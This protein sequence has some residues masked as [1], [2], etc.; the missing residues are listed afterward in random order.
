[1][2]KIKKTSYLLLILYCWSSHG[3]VHL[4]TN[5]ADSGPGS[6]RQAII[7]ANADGSTPRTINFAIGAGV[8][9]ISPVTALPALVVP[10][11]IIDG[12]TQ[13]GW[14]A[15]NP[16]IVIDGTNAAFGF[17]G[18]TI[19]ATDACTI[20]DL[21]INNGFNS[22]ITI[23]GN[24]AD[25][26][27]Y[28]CFIGV[29]QTGT[30]AAPNSL[31]IT[32]SAT[33][34]EQNNNTIIGAPTRGN[35]VSGNAGFFGAGLFL[36]GNL[37]DMVVQG[38]FIGTDITGTV[39][40]ANAQV[41][42]AIISQP[43]S[44]AVVCNGALIGGSGAGE[45]NVMSGNST[46]PGLFM[47]FQNV[48]DTIIQ[49]NK[50][51]VDVT[52]TVAVP[53]GVGI[54][55]FT[56]EPANFLNGTILGGANAGEGNVI[57]ANP[58]GGVGLQV[59]CNNSIIK[60]NFIG[61]DI[62]GTVA[63]G[64]GNGINIQGNNNIIGGSTAAERNIIS[65]NTGSGVFIG[66]GSSSNVVTGNYIG[67]D[68]T[69]TVAMG[70]NNIGVEITGYDFGTLT[71]IPSNSNIVGGA[72]AGERNII[73]NSGSSGILLNMG[74]NDTVIKG[75]Y[76]GVDVTGAVD[77]GNSNVG[78][79]IQGYDFTNQITVPC[80]RTIIGGAV[81]GEGNVIAGSTNQ[82]IQ[83]NLGINDS[84]IKGNKIGVDV[85]GLV[86][87][88]NG[89]QGIQM[90]GYD[91]TNKTIVA[92]DNTVI[93]GATTNE[94]N[95]ISG[96][97]NTGIQLNLGCNNTVIKGNYIGVDA[98]GI[99]A[100]SNTNQGI[101]I[102][103]FDFNPP[104][105]SAPCND[106][107][108][109]G[110]LAGERN[111]ISAN[112]NEG[113]QLNVDANDTII[114]GNYIGVGS[115]GTTALGNANQG[116]HVIGNTLAATNGTI[117]GGSATG[118]SNIISSN[119][120]DGIF[121]NRN[122]NNSVI[123]GNFIGTD[124]TG[125]LNRANG[126]NGINITGDTGQ[127]SDNTI[128]GGAAS[129]AGNL[130]VANV[131][132]GILL[133]NNVNNTVIK[134]NYVGTNSASSTILGNGSMGIQVNGNAAQPCVG[135]IIGGPLA[136]EGNVI[137]NN[138]VDGIWLNTSVN[139]SIIQGNFIG[140]NKTATIDLGNGDDGIQISGAGGAPC[141]NNLIGGTATAQKNII[142][143][144]TN[145]GVTIGGDAGSPDILNSVL[146]NPIY[147]NGNNGIELH[148]GGNNE[149]E[150]PTVDSV[151]TCT[152]NNTVQVT[153]TAPANPPASSF[154]LEYFLNTVDR[155]PITEGETFIGFTTPVPSGATVTNVF[156]APSASIGQWFSATAT[157]L[158]NTGGTPGDTSEFS[159]NRQIEAAIPP[160]VSLVATPTIICAGGSSTLTVTI[161]GTSPY[162][163]VW[164]DGLV[165]TDVTSPVQRVVTPSTTTVY[166]VTATDDVSCGSTS[167]NATVVVNPL[168]TVTLTADPIST[169][170]GGTVT[171]TATPSG[172]GP[173]TLEWS[174]G[175]VQNNVAGA[176][177][178]EVIINAPTTYSVVATDSNGCVSAPAQVQ[179]L[180]GK[181]S[182]IV[183]A[184]INKYCPNL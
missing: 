91:F 10:E 170:P 65:N 55:T 131:S 13:P 51:G 134:G 135:T 159:L 57:S 26:A 48:Q 67:V 86:A 127:L 60:G 138:T 66:Q 128:I 21:V 43:S 6:L 154:R 59:N 121:L 63:L 44:T 115:D 54:I 108:I 155:N 1:M 90:Y 52:G 157:N 78:I 24:A 163:L 139:D 64:N 137:G 45:G 8:Q 82:G 112:L 184:I 69:G 169:L 142:T 9:T 39:G 89:Q 102:S 148:D 126:Q 96:N 177:M 40:I 118:E 18:L 70:N 171:L 84:V 17:D 50:I 123:Q 124:I 93:G 180:I 76:I 36:S 153:V 174:D 183:I 83:L 72:S 150:A 25:N 22:G 37:N 29:D 53:N 38:N 74:C 99:A 120:N 161:T 31:G 35:L 34:G 49:G 80:N 110:A 104:E 30:T 85:T 46:G 147:N 152:F 162:D 172:N 20:Q 33:V 167:N 19:N 15:G 175:L 156:A 111:I 168:P 95:I 107:I 179:V 122:V 113:I 73:S 32:V 68:I 47:G 16:V 173:F 119:N 149:Q 12:S 145:F 166:F 87:I 101:Q 100:L 88:A 144:N 4:V 178:R 27:I 79:Q 14:S 23:M 165:Q 133:Q 129:G 158:N 141:T 71:P 75:N 97:G 92:C 136:N 3:A 11:I 182:P 103:G 116:I 125:T 2:H 81:A 132:N 117:I 98:T 106:T 140:T 160:V 94:R 143:F 56:D 58:G 109:G 146:G 164:S 5:T 77:F 114:K 105:T 41:G 130:I 181:I 42:L 62:T 7:D 28:G 151:L 61:T 176:V